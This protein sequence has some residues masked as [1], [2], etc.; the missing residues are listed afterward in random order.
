MKI[1]VVI[2]AFNEER[3]IVQTLRQVR[4]AMGAFDAKGWASELIV[5][6]NNSTDRTADLATAEGATVVFEPVNQIGR[7]RNC[8]AQAATGDWLLFIDADS[9][10]ELALLE[11]VVAAIESGNYLAG[12]S[13]VRIEGDYPFTKFATGLWNRLSR[14]QRWV[15]G[16]FIFCETSAFREVGGF[17]LGLYASEEIALSKKLKLLAKTRKK[18]LIILH[19]HP[20]LTSARKMNLYS[21]REHLM[22][23]L[24]TMFSGGRTLNSREACHTW[25]DGRR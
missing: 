18:K 2:P 24:R 4:E 22:F 17:D 25:Y 21:K 11:A 7:A 13:T 10:P 9:L 12:G 3:L 15:A 8:G 14:W 20:L 19:H 5:C 1:S 23:L 16:S 6:N